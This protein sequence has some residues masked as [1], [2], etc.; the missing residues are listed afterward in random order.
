MGVSE[1]GPP[2]ACEV[3]YAVVDKTRSRYPAKVDNPK[4]L[5]K[6]RQSQ[7]KKGNLLVSHKVLVSLHCLVE[8]SSSCLMSALRKVS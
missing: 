2:P 5:A 4:K 7:A 1:P 8:N 6:K 3:L